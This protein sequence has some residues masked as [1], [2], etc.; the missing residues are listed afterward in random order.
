MDKRLLD[1]AS[2]PPIKVIARQVASVRSTGAGGVKTGQA[3]CHLLV[4]SH[5]IHYSI[6]VAPFAPGDLDISA[7]TWTFAP[8]AGNYPIGG[9]SDLPPPSG[10][11]PLQ[12][13]ISAGALPDGY[14]GESLTQVFRATLNID[15][16]SAIGQAQGGI[17]V[18]AQFEPAEFNMSAEERSFW[19]N[20]CQ[21]MVP[22]VAL[23]LSYSV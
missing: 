8:C 17:W 16:G 20:K 5:R 3:I 2:V 1:F 15:I 4:P 12:P 19:F 21:L 6:D 13:I 10:F 7:S 11:S 22:P 23:D 9:G 18:V 14:E